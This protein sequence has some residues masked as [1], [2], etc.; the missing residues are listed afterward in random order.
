M[1]TEMTRRGFFRKGLS[2]AAGAVAV[3]AVY[4]RAAAAGGPKPKKPRMHLG[5]VTYLI[6]AKMDLPTLIKTCE[7]SGMEGVELR[8]LRVQIENRIDL[9]RALGLSQNPIIEG[10]DITVSARSDSGC[11]SSPFA[12]HAMRSMRG[13]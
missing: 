13:A 11:R 6:G 1:A 9:S 2:A 7:K 3:G 10:V 8:E 5:L 4:P 12:R